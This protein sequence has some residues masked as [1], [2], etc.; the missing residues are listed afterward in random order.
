MKRST[1]S[2]EEIAYGLLRVGCGTAAGEVC[3]WLDEE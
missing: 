1:L 2:E 3:R